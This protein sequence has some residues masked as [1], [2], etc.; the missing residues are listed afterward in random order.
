MECCGRLWK[1]FYKREITMPDVRAARWK[2]EE[3]CGIP[4][5]EDDSRISACCLEEEGE[6]KVCAS[7]VHK[8]QSVVLDR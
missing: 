1:V 5:N 3:R 8:I 6:C 7:D 4:W 2:V